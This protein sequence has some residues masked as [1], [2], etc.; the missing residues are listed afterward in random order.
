VIPLVCA[1]FAFFW[2]MLRKPL[3]KNCRHAAVSP[4]QPFPPA[5]RSGVFIK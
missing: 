2:L 1:S 4:P 3:G 5:R